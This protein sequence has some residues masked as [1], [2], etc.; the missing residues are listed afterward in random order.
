MFST[1]MKRT[2]SLPRP[3]RL[4]KSTLSQLILE[5]T[6]Y[7]RD[8]S[9]LSN[10]EILVCVCVYVWWHRTQNRSPIERLINSGSSILRDLYSVILA[11]NGIF[12]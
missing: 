5:I 7:F 12:N 6:L 2:D 3:A 11:I 1:Y 9:I 10:G 8:H 4:L